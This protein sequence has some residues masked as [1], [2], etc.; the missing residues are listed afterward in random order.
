MK[1]SNSEKDN[2]EE[3]DLGGAVTKRAELE[4][5]AAAILDSAEK[6]QTAIQKLAPGLIENIQKSFEANID[7]DETFIDENGE[8]QVRKGTGKI[9]YS[10][11]IPKDYS[12]N[13]RGA[14]LV[15][16][17]DVQIINDL[18][19][20]DGNV[21]DKNARKAYNY[22]NKFA[23]PE[24]ALYSLAF[25][26]ADDTPSFQNIKKTEIQ[27]PIDAILQKVEQNL[28]TGTGGAQFLT[29]EGEL[30]T[31]KQLAK[32]NVAGTLNWINSTLDYNKGT[33]KQIFN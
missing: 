3:S 28:L 4:A 26:I 9:I 30:R 20:T 33:Q 25:E 24:D 21:D 22:F 27:E 7:S 8:E 1:K 16:E 10:Y 23:R 11:T 12:K 19:A 15:A 6:A 18:L 29:K 13:D 31:D 5:P 32:Q 17:E 2:S 14:N